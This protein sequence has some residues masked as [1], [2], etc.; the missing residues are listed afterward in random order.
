MRKCHWTYIDDHHRQHKVGLLHSPS[1]GHVLLY[2][3]NKIILVDFLVF[4]TKSYSFLINEELCEV[5]I[6]RTPNSYQYDFQINEKVDTPRNRKRRERRRQYWIQSI[7]ALAGFLTVFALAGFFFHQWQDRRSKSDTAAAMAQGTAFAKAYVAKDEVYDSRLH[8]FYQSNTRQWHEGFLRVDRDSMLTAQGLPIEDGD[9]FM[10]EY[11]LSD[12]ERSVLHLDQPS[13]RQLDR[14]RQAVIQAHSQSQ[15]SLQPVYI[16]CQVDQ[17]YH[18]FGLRGWAQLYHQ[19]HLNTANERFNR[20][21]FE[22]FRQDPVYL[23]KVVRYC[24]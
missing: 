7:A 24:Q 3:N 18:N 4:N 23:E 5:K 11:A 12:P 20:S 15:S 6:L 10:V 19:F 16:R 17:V 13:P 2:C 14:Y 1:K 8:Y 22:R 9:E 21:T